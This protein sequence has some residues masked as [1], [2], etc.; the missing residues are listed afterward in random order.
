MSSA[1]LMARKLAAY[2]KE[3]EPHLKD[4][5]DRQK[6]ATTKP[7][8]QPSD[9]NWVGE[10]AVA[11][12]T[13]DASKAPAKPLDTAVAAPNQTT[14]LLAPSRKAPDVPIIVPEGEDSLAATGPREVS[15][16]SDQ[17]MGQLS[18]KVKENPKDVAAQL[19]YQLMQFLRGEQV[20]Q[21][22]NLAGL[23]SEDREVIAALM[24]GLS[25]FRSNARNEGNQ[26][27]SQK[28]RPLTEMADR[29]R[30]Q[31]DLT[32]PNAVLC[33]RVDGYGVYE[34][35]SPRFAAGKKNPVI[36]YCEVENFASQ[37]NDKKQWETRL[38][39]EAILYTETG[40]VAWTDKSKS[41]V[42][43]SRN[44]RHDFFIVKKTELPVLPL[45][46]Y[47]LKISVTDQQSNRVAET[48]IPIT[49][50]AE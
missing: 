16:N 29:M 30:G 13:A 37:I 12:A 3:L 23:P 48:T 50:G 5:A 26:M 36:V 32:L 44:R 42:D 6:P 17:L 43:T 7:A 46:R 27:L 31:A 21:M 15:V 39:N 9:V 14:V 2:S 38:A 4:R 11:A 1:A 20:P 25:N 18:T 45:G 49:I 10:G 35:M 33:N 47:I 28:I 19:D 41:I 24:D 22:K 34:P 8:E 40:M